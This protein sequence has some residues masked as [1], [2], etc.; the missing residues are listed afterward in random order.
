VLLGTDGEDIFAAN[1]DLDAERRAQV[2][3]L[4]DPATHKEVSEKTRHLE[5]DRKVGGY[6]D[7]QPWDVSRRRSR[8]SFVV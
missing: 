3:T 5:A 1:A 7:C 6:T 2:G 4:H 8:N